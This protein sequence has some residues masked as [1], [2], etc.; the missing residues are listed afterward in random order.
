VYAATDGGSD[1]LKLR[2]LSTTVSSLDRLGRREKS[3]W[4]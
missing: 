1:G 3:R 4:G 2:W